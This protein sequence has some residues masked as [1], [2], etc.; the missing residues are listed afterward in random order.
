MFPERFPYSVEI[1]QTPS[2]YVMPQSLWEEVTRKRSDIRNIH[3]GLDRKV[4]SSE[5][6]QRCQDG[7]GHEARV[8]ETEEKL[9]VTVGSMW[10]MAGKVKWV[11]D[12]E[13]SVLINNFEKRGW[14]QVAENEDWNFYWMSVQTIRNV[15]SVE[16]GYRL[17]DDQIV[18]H[19]PNHYELTRKDLMVKNIK[20]YRKELEKEGSPLAEKDENGKYLYLD[21][22][23]VTYM[24]PAD[25]N[26]FVEEFRKNPSSTWIMKPCGKAQGKGIFLINKLSQIKKWSRDSKTSSFVSQSTKEAYVISLYINNPLLIGGK[27]FD[28]RLYVLV[29][30]YRPLRCYMYKLGFCRFCT[31]KYTRSTSE[32]DNMFV[33]LTNVA[34]Q[35]HG[36][37]YNHIHGGKWTVSNLRLY[38][39]STRG[40]EVTNKLF[41]EIHWI[42]VQSLKAVA[43]VMNNDKH[44]FECY[45]YDIIIDDKLKPWLIEERGS[46]L[47]V[48][49][50]LELSP[51][52]SLTSSELSPQMRAQWPRCP[53]VARKVNASPSLSSSTASDR[54]LKYGLVSDTLNI[55]VPGGM[56]PDCRWNKSPPKEV[57]GNYE[58]LNVMLCINIIT[59]VDCER[60]PCPNDSAKTI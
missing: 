45:G 30:T 52:G 59:D 20:R 29:S 28:L 55:A 40:K 3:K 60:L 35:K 1:S 24:L 7:E 38:L 17:S 39:E 43:P 23:P 27:K 25:Y 14:V 50:W 44:C 2:P 56:V 53:R 51:L 10:I 18:N 8:S 6:Q 22:V 47:S 34:I 36:E 48:C 9:D 37:D 54:V 5:C 19:F 32:L 11:T 57:L 12:I 15:F 16:T 21:F 31:V 46:G 13:K 42:I 49:R 26:L 4:G 33:H 41:D 58:I